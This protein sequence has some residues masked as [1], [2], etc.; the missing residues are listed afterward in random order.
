MPALPFRL[1][2]ISGSHPLRLP[3][4]PSIQL[5]F[6]RFGRRPPQILKMPVELLEDVHGLPGDIP[7]NVP[8]VLSMISR[9]MEDNGIPWCVVGD[10]LLAH[11]RVPKITGDIEICIPSEDLARAQT[12]IGTLTDFCSPFRP[13]HS[14]YNRHLTRFPRFKVNGMNQ[15]FALVPAC[16]FG[17]PAKV[18]DTIMH[19]PH[20]GF[21]LLPLPYYVGGM[22]SVAVNQGTDDN[23]FLSQIE[24]LIDGMDIEEEWCCKYLSG[25]EQEFVQNKSTRGAKRLRMGSHPKYEG[26]L[27]TYIH[28][29]SER[30][31]VLTVIGR[32]LDVN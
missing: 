11:Y 1:P 28:D 12:A 29:E 10:L 9:L 6:P 24:F 3:K 21:P 20:V 26:N 8:Q 18:F 23:N 30:A 7:S 15:C 32:D 17:M 25:S 13:P 27:T 31:A 16:H 4:M 22:V 19:P 14:Y 5:R 2:S